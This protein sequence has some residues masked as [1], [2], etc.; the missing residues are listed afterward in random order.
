MVIFNQMTLKWPKKWTYHKRCN[1]IAHYVTINW[2][3]FQKPTNETTGAP[4]IDKMGE[5]VKIN[6]FTLVIIFVIFHRNGN[7]GFKMKILKFLGIHPTYGR[8]HVFRKIHTGF[9]HYSFCHIPSYSFRI[10]SL[11]MVQKDKMHFHFD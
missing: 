4:Y 1:V 11:P 5:F 3:E 10:E 8:N 9:S 6:E 7:L 2:F